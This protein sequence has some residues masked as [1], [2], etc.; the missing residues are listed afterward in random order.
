[1]AFTVMPWTLL[2]TRVMGD[3]SGYTVYTDRFGRKIWYKKAPP[4]EPPSPRQLEQRRRFRDAV[5]AW[6]ALSEPEK[7]ALEEAV[8]KTSLCLTGQNLFTS[9]ALKHA[10]DVYATLAKQTGETLPPLPFIT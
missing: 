3:V 5:N 10:D 8:R 1:M 6:I 9:C 2:G 7:L 4:K